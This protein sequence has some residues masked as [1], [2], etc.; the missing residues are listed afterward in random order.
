MAINKVA[1]KKTLIV[2]VKI[3][4]DEDGKDM[5]KSQSFSS[6]KVDATD[7]QIY[8]VGAAFNTLG[9]FPFMSIEVQDRAVLNQA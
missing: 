1:E 6:M 4:T 5:M 8:A 3:G 7:D 2:T 9:V